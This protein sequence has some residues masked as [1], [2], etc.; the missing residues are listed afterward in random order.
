MSKKKLRRIR[1]DAKKEITSHTLDREKYSARIVSIIVTISIVLLTIVLRYHLLPAPLERDEGEY[2]Y[3]GQLLLHG[4]LPYTEIYNMKLPGIYFVYAAIVGIFGETPNG[5][6]IAL[7]L[8]NVLTS[9]LLFFFIKKLFGIIAGITGVSVFIVLSASRHFQGAFANA[10]HFIIVCVLC[11]IFLLLKA[12]DARRLFLMFLSGFVFGFAFL[13][14]QHGIFFV[15]FGF[16]YLCFRNL[17]SEK[18]ICKISLI[19]TA[20]FILGVCLPFA[21]SCLL[22]IYLG[23]FDKF[24]FWT[25]LYAREYTGIFTLS[26]GVGR[27]FNQL[28]NLIDSVPLL[29]IWLLSPLGLIALFIHKDI[30]QHSVLVTSFVTFSFLSITPGFYFR[31][32]YF[33]LFLPALAFLAGAACVLLNNYLSRTTKVSHYIILLVVFLILFNSIYKEK[34]Y[35]FAADPVNVTRLTYGIYHPFPES[36]EVGRYIRNN[37][38]P[39]DLVAIFGSE[40]QI[41]FYSKRQSASGYIYMYPFT[42]NQIYAT[43]MWNEMFAEVKKNKPKI[44]VYVAMPSSWVAGY[45]P[46]NNIK[47][48]MKSIKFFTDSYYEPSGAVVSLPTG[49]TYYWDAE[50]SKL[51]ESPSIV[52]YKRKAL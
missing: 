23:I 20:L 48:I 18:F 46:N 37:S 33:V 31:P 8:I 16:F 52:I 1:A 32:H 25:V 11:A 50:L 49:I 38:S 2:A 40:P 36:V 24:W 29:L 44:V 13:I 43:Q 3:A 28:R 9:I 5:I 17:T 26:E 14:K 30:K 21:A 42:E 51:S 6:H 10:E 47:E 39:S 19:R 27:L 7:L 12:L 35:F 4:I 22:Y 15:L 34:N 41:L 45:K